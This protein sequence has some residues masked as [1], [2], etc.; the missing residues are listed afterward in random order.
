MAVYVDDILCLDT[1]GGDRALQNLQELQ[2]R[3]ELKI[4]GQAAHVLG[5]RIEQTEDAIYL[6]QT[7]FIQE[8]L[9]ETGEAARTPVV[10]PWDGKTVHEPGEL[11]KQKQH[12]SY[13]NK[14]GKLLYL[15]GGTRPDIAF[16]LSK[17]ASAAVCPRQADWTRLLRVIRYLKGTQR[18]RIRYQRAGGNDQLDLH[19]YADSSFGANPT[20]GKSI[21]GVLV[22]LAGGSVVWRSHLQE[23]TADSSNAA[24]YVAL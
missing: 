12:E 6:D 3:W 10:N 13:R 16:A 14:L 8:I 7:A 2:R 15:A 1:G 4:I 9:L 17:L 23:T 11:L 20:D 5:M 22:K 21:T 18:Y 24:E 19:R